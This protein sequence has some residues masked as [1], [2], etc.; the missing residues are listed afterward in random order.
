MATMS[1]KTP[2]GSVN[3]HVWYRG[4][5]TS[6]GYE[7]PRAP[8]G[9]DAIIA[10]APIELWRSNACNERLVTLTDGAGLDVV[11][12][13][14]YTFRSA[15]LA[16]RY[17]RIY[18]VF[19][20]KCGHRYRH[21]Y[22]GLRFAGAYF[23]WSWTVSAVAIAVPTFMAARH[24]LAG[25]LWALHAGPIGGGAVIGLADVAARLYYRC[26][27][28]ARARKFN[29]GQCPHCAS[30]RKA[31]PGIYRGDLPCPG[32][33]CRAMKLDRVDSGARQSDTPGA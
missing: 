25:A 10:D 16:G 20:L 8:S 14:G 24:P 21:Q 9:A 33:G 19:C 5:C 31:Y 4:R 17:L 29:L 27:Y 32:C 2:S 11:T 12:R 1:R 28:P 13:T 30:K 26:A 7:T 6:C 18:Y 15:V 23:W 22:M 3:K